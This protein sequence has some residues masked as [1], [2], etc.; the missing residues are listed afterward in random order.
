MVRT[1]YAMHEGAYVE[2][3][4]HENYVGWDTPESF[5]WAHA[6]M[7]QAMAW[8]EVPDSG[9]LLEIGCGA[10]NYLVDL[11]PD[12]TLAGIDISPT[13]IEWAGERAID[14][15]V[16]ADLRV[17]DVRELPW[18]DASFDVVRDG[19]LLH[20]II[21][22]DRSAVLGEAMRVLRPGGVFVVFTMVGD[23]GIPVEQWDPATRLCMYQGVAVRYVGLPEGIEGELRDAGFEVLRSQVFDD[24]GGT[25]E[26]V[27]VARKP[28]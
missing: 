9:A 19:H 1:D 23:K 2:R 12:F 25:D 21:G 10:G 11:A 16:E 7:R 5:E 13:A 27:V 26:L 3:R 18:G 4:Q 20:C 14:A 24:Y 22:E 8:P 6:V 17:G 28:E 15:G